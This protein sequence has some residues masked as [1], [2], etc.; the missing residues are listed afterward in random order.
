METGSL[1]WVNLMTD[2]Y[3][4]FAVWVNDAKESGAP[5]PEK[6]K[7]IVSLFDN[8]TFAEPPQGASRKF[9]DRKFVNSIREKFDKS[10]KLSE[11]Q[12]Q[13]LAVLAARYI[14]Q[15]DLQSLSA[16]LK[17]LLDAALKASQEKVEKLKNRPPA[18][19]DGGYTPVFASFANVQ[20]ATPKSTRKNAFNEEKFFKSLK[21]QA[22]SGSALS[23]KQLAALKRM[24]VKY[25]DQLT[26]KNKV[27]ELLQITDGESDSAS[28]TNAPKITPV[29]IGEIINALNQITEWAPAEKKGRFTFDDKK[30][31]QSLA[32]HYAEKK[33]L[34]D[35]QSAALEKLAAKYLK[36][37]N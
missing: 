35:K 4:S 27:F 5:A 28:D 32:R 30:F 17:E 7:E 33:S 19:A 22:E 23:E 2:F 11:K 6:A 24:A 15:I 1:N 25:Q 26:D 12:Y 31:F 8:I 9:D 29:Q 13:A 20:F 21:K 16:D 34:S 18:P 14:D 37:S 3:A 36:P 10:G